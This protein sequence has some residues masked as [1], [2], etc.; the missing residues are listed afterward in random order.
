MTDRDTHDVRDAAWFE[1]MRNAEPDHERPSNEEL[2][3]DDEEYREFLEEWKRDP[4]S[5]LFG[6]GL[7]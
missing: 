2:A 6:R 7:S 4:K 3:L 1:R 5:W